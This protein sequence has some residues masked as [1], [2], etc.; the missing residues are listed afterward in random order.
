MRL[1]QLVVIVL[2][3]G[4]PS[5]QPPIVVRTELCEATVVVAAAS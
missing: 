2:G 1:L 3:I 5:V 4:V